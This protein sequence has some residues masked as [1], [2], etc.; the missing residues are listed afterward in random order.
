MSLIVIEAIF[1]QK[2]KNSSISIGNCLF[3]YP[4]KCAKRLKNHQII[5]LLLYARYKI[6]I[7]NI[8]LC[9]EYFILLTS[10]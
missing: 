1:I 7:E 3:Y 6:F 8:I 4:I 10:G 5:Q 9:D 2:I